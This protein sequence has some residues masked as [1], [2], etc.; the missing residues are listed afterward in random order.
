LYEKCPRRFFYTH[1]LG[2]GGARKSTAFSRTEDCIYG[3]I[4]WL[5]SQ[6]RTSNPSEVDALIEFE[7]IWAQRGPVDHAFADDYR[8]L[9][10]QLVQSLVALGA[11]RRFRESQPLAIDF[12]H[13][14]VIVEP[15]EMAELPDGTV[16][17]RKVRTGRKRKTEYDELDYTLYHLAAKKHFGTAYAFEAVHLAD[18]LVEPVDVTT[19]KMKNRQKKGDEYLAGIAAGEFPPEIDAI[20]CPRCP[21]FFICAATPKGPV[22]SA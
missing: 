13:G 3:V 4:R 17:L 8:N 2:L 5:A 12:V 9:A 10:S 7:R 1:V 20:S 11:G 21:H 18:G 19:A 22:T 6:R 15:D 16:V 14:K